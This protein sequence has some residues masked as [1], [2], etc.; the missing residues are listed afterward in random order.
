MSW[1]RPVTC[2]FLPVTRPAVIYGSIISGSLHSLRS[3]SFAPRGST[4]TDDTHIGPRHLFCAAGHRRSSRPAQQATCSIWQR[5]GRRDITKCRS[6]PCWTSISSAW[7]ASGP[8][9]LCF[10]QRAAVHESCYRH[11]VAAWRRGRPVPAGAALV[12]PPHACIG[13]ARRFLIAGASCGKSVTLACGTRGLA[14]AHWLLM[15]FPSAFPDSAVIRR[16]N[17]RGAPASR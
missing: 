4:A 2:A 9:P 6:P 14:Q 16:M 15:V 11:C 1:A 5:K 10:A 3:C 17:E 7:R 12:C 8:P 13:L